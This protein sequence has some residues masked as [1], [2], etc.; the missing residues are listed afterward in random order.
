MHVAK[1]VTQRLGGERG[2]CQPG[3]HAHECAARAARAS[4]ISTDSDDSCS[5]WAA[6]GSAAIT[7]ATCSR[8]LRELQAVAPPALPASTRRPPYW[9]STVARRKALGD[10]VERRAMRLPGQTNAR[11]DT[12]AHGTPMR[13]LARAAPPDHALRPRTEPS[14]RSPVPPFALPRYTSSRRDPALDF[15]H[16]P[17]P[18]YTTSRCDPRLIYLRAFKPLAAFSGATLRA[19]LLAVLVEAEVLSTTTGD[20]DVAVAAHGAATRPSKGC[21][22][23][24]LDRGYARDAHAAVGKLLAAIARRRFRPREECPGGTLAKVPDGSR[25]RRAIGR[26]CR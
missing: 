20:H 23:E 4:V 19:A 13:P 17:L 3:L 15:T 11:T 8:M 16:A 14:R 21:P 1:T 26:R 25:S 10:A 6:S 2:C 9:K 5:A 7:R 22:L 18:R 12:C 24:N